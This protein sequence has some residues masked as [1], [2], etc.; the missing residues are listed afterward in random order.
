MQY[1]DRE[2]QYLKNSKKPTQ[3][4]LDNDVASLL[5]KLGYKNVSALTP[6]FQ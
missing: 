1:F 6:L 3:P 5:F 4:V 2:M